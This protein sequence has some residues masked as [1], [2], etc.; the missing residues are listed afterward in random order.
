MTPNSD[1]TKSSRTGNFANSLRRLEDSD[2]RA[3][4]AA[5]RSG[6]KS[7]DGFALP[8]VAFVAPFLGEKEGRND[9]W[10]YAIAALFAL[11]PM[12][13]GRGSLGTAFSR[14]RK[15]SDSIEKRF[16]MLLACNDSELFRHLFQTVSLL[17]SKAVPVDWDRLLRDLLFNDWDAPDRTLQR[18]WAHDFYH[19]NFGAAPASEQSNS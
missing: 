5:L 1:K 14:L 10:F 16:Q 18:R 17:E 12:R 15:E 11:H 9:Q 19:T 3:A 8:M 7:R 6:L 13:G 2:D 4:L